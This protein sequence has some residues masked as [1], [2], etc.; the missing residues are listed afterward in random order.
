MAMN[1]NESFINDFS[2]ELI[3]L[4]NYIAS[5]DKDFFLYADKIDHSWSAAY[6]FF[7]NHLEL[8][9]IY[10]SYR[11]DSITQEELKV[12][13]QNF[14]QVNAA[15]IKAI[16]GSF[17][18][19]PSV[20]IKELETNLYRKMVRM[21]VLE[22][23]KNQLP[24]KDLNDNIETAVKSA[25]YMNYRH[26]YNLPELKENQPLYSAIFLFIRNYAYSGMFRYSSKGDFNVP[27]GGIAYNSKLLKKKLDYYRSVPLLGH[28]RTTHIYN[29]D[30]EEF[31][32]LTG[33][34]END[35]VFLDPPYDSEFSTYAQN[36]FSRKDQERLAAY[37]INRCRAK[38]MLIIK[39]TDFIFNLY[40][41]PGINIKAFDKNY[42]VSFMNRNDKKVTHL[43]ITNYVCQ[44]TELQNLN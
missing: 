1:S 27:Y 7:Q 24:D 6:D 33:P 22:A 9:D 42:T 25:V 26:L 30:F 31:L 28:F 4:Y 23:Q 36:E 38:W 14:C 34:E 2:T 3:N 10:N 35:F 20:L 29:L 15:E 11:T 17:R 12:R 18:D 13:I 41:K 37:L 43:L 40:D 21:K 32:N 16:I 5:S 39:N 19:L 44:N 8:I